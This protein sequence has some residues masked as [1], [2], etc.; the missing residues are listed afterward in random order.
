MLRLTESTI[1]GQVLRAH[2]CCVCVCERDGER[3]IVCVCV[4]VYV[5][6]YPC[7]YTIDME[8]VMWRS[9]HDLGSVP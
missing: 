2:V 1:R 9:D 7:V 3:E 5:C 8:P 4:C 6:V